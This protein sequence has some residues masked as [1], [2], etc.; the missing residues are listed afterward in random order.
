MAVVYEQ[1]VPVLF[2]TDALQAMST[3]AKE[4]NKKRAFICCDKGVRQ[5]GGAD[6]VEA[7][8]K[9]AG[10]ETYVFDECMPDPTDTFI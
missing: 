10:L 1:L 3:K 6:A 7:V 4:L 9:N 8:L 5:A 2:G